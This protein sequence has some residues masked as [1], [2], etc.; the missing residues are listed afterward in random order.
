[1]KRFVRPIWIY[2]VATLFFSV[3]SNVAMAYIPF[4]TQTL[5][6]QQYLLAVEGYIICIFSYL[7]CNFIQMRIDWR[8]SIVFSNL[9]KNSWFDAIQAMSQK[10]F[11]E[12]S[13][14][15]YV[16]Y[17]SND[18]DALEKDYLPP[19]LS[20][21][22]QILQMI[23]YT[24]VISQ[25]INPW[26]AFILISCSILSIQIPKVL[27]KKTA[28]KRK[29]YLKAQ[30]QY[31]D[32]LD[33]LL[34]GHHLVTEKTQKAMQK[35]QRQS[36]AHLQ[37]NYYRY[38]MMKVWGLVL[39]GASYELTGV[40]LF[41][42]LAYSLSKGQITIPEV[43]ASISY[44]SAFSGPIQEILYDVQMLESVKPVKESFLSVV[45]QPVQL[46]REV[47][48]FHTLQL[49]NIRKNIGQLVLDIPELTIQ[50]GDKIAL[51][52]E[53]GSGKSSFLN[54]LN[55][56]DQPDSGEFY[57]DG[58]LIQSLEGAFGKIVQ[59][60]H[61]FKGS[62]K[63]N[64]TLFDSYSLE[65]FEQRFIT[66]EARQLSGGEKQRMYLSREQNH[67]STFLI[68]DEP[69]SAMD[70]EQLKKELLKVLNDEGTVLLTIHQNKDLLALFDRVW[71]LKNGKIEI[72]K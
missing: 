61:T 18:L 43:A 65:Q 56:I 40:V 47:H 31:Y 12:K 68:L 5:L 13:V 70:A 29:I 71:C 36:L 58:Q 64:V 48:S 37:E 19:L 59:H 38:G 33:D 6:K 34:S 11:A 50:K 2:C 8:Q 60:E 17:Q 26:V 39:T 21:I 62:Y 23:V 14:P 32:T 30:G 3:L 72:V 1:M 66:K 28:K 15:E 53:N 41:L 69:F 22:R 46:K 16:A 51:I 10:K 49:K 52:G 7:V 54:L 9:L 24:V 25:T 4:F 42:Y 55:G 57:L 27:G 45:N 20:F 35:V 63:D 44:I 67:Q